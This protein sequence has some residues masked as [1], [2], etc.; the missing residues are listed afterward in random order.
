MKKYFLLTIILI[1]LVTFAKS[2]NVYTGPETAVNF[3]DNPFLKEWTTP[4]G[5]PPFDQ[6]KNEHYIPAFEK[7]IEEQNQEIAA[8]V[9]NPEPPNFENTLA[10]FDRSG[11]LLEKVSSVFFGLNGANTNAEMQEI[12][13]KLSPILSKHSD[14]INLNPKLFERVKIVY[15]SREKLKYDQE[16]L[17]L[18]EETFKNFKRGGAGLDSAGKAHL[19]E[20]NKEISMLQLTFGQNLLAENNAY[21]LVIDNKEDLS[22]LPLD[23]ITAAA[24]AA[25]ADP[26]TKGKWVFTLQNPSVMPFLQFSDKR[27]LREK[28]FMAYINRCNN[29]DS[30][31]NKKIIAKLVAL[32]GK[33]AKLMGFKSY[34]DF[35]LDDRMAKTPA[36]VYDLLN[37]I[38]T[39]ALAMAKKER[40]NMQQMITQGGGTFELKSW[41]WR[42]YSEK[43]RKASF[44]L[45]EETVKPYFRLE[46]VRDGIFYVA[47]KLYGITFNEVTD[48]P[49]YYPGVKLYECHDR[50][51]D[52]LGVVYM[53]FFP[54]AGKR[55]GAWCGSFRSQSNKDGQRVPPVMT[56]VTN[57]SAPTADKPALLTADEVET[58]F[59]EFGHNLAGLFRNVRY[60]GIGGVPR[61]FVELPSQMNEHWAFEPEVLKVY[62][63]HYLTGEVIPQELVDKILKSGKY[64]EGFKTTEYLAASFLDMDYHTSP[65]AGNNPDVLK[66]E[67]ESMNKIGLIEQIPPRYRSTYFQHSMTGGYTAGYYSYIWA[68]VL[69]ADAFEAFKETGNIFDQATATKFRK[70]ILEKGGS[71]DAMQLY[72]DF[73]GKQPSIDALLENR[74][75]K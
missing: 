42:Y 19:R 73:R 14:D 62:A 61:D 52:L 43:V 32:R 54:R 69:D 35:V 9:F 50:G 1:V 33:K 29:N 55:G 8:I 71:K 47:N 66:F 31:D 75:L 13:K 60:D 48:A 28:I 11:K 6:I 27:E 53:D 25:N 24:E 36:N 17:R 39:P 45:A 20:L 2:Q 22:G 46:N 16:Q 30:R 10:A 64:G 21:K 40:E 15:G 57:F 58:F 67:T 3:S 12:A 41:D 37:K 26:A 59:H 63:K 49:T 74:G 70:D 72:L 23:L 44:D 51:G 4:F 38:W 68:E 5:V 7:G 56:I 18:I 34:A 65:E